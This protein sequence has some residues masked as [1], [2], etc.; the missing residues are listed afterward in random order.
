MSVVDISTVTGAAHRLA[1]LSALVKWEVY[2]QA[3]FGEASA[4]AGADLVA[5]KKKQHSFS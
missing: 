2:L 4:G 1:I 3:V 5:V